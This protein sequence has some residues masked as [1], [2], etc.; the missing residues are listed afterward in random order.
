MS[1]PMRDQVPYDVVNDIFGRLPV[2]SLTRFRSVSKT[3]NSIISDPTFVSTLFN[4]TLTKS[5]IST[6]THGGY[7]LYTPTVT[8]DHSSS[9][10][11]Q[12]CTVVCN[13]DRTLTQ[14]SKFDIPSFPDKFSIVGFYN[15]VFCLA[16]YDQDHYHIIYLWNP[17]IRKFKKLRSTRFLYSAVRV[18]FGFAFDPKNNDFKVLKLVTFREKKPLAEAEIYTLSTDSWRKD[19]ITMESLRGNEPNFGSIVSVLPPSVFCNGALHFIANTCRHRF[20]L[21]FDVHDETFHEM[22]LPLPLRERQNYSPS[23]QLAVFKGLLAVLFFSHGVGCLFHFWVM[24][25]YGVVGSWT[26]K[27]LIPADSPHEFYCSTDNGELL[28]KSANGMVSINPPE[29]LNWSLLA[30]EDANWVG[31]SANSMESLVLHD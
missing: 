9:T 27:C 18:V 14:V 5:L 7:L 2:K 13:N 26:R 3:C 4:L 10:S 1:Q 16:S 25:K 22:M 11:K 12:L 6:N 20:I 8:A 17:S 30:I 24:E 21:S 28:F 23:F 15:S 31:F 19:I 29:S